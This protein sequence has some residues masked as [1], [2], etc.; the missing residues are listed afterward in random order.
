MNFHTA[1]R[2]MPLAPGI[3]TPGVIAAHEKPS[4][5]IN[6]FDLASVMKMVEELKQM[7]LDLQEKSKHIATAQELQTAH[8]EIKTHAHKLVSS[9]EAI[10][11]GP[12]GDRGNPGKDVALHAVVQEVL[13]RIPAPKD[14]DTPIVDEKRIAKRVAKL[15]KLPEPP[16]PQEPNH[17]LVIEKIVEMLQGGKIKIHA[18]HIEGLE[19]TI[20]PVRDLARRASI[21]GGGDTVAA[22]TNVTLT[23]LP[24]GQVQISTTSGSSSKTSDLSSQCT[25]SNKVFTIPAFT[26]ILSLIG[27][28]A[29]IV[30]R[31]TIDFVASGTT[32]TLQAGVT[33]P[34]SGATLLLTYV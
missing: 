19:Q 23:R 32:L 2:V 8:E 15:V 7:M 31:P 17:E 20:G 4:Q 34:S 16:A 10:K 30:Y 27:T 25:G 13:S 5:G 12:K 14:G 21:R 11:Q 33:A 9:F 26:T 28:D 22:G 29:P 6:P 3:K 18:S 24:S 1:R